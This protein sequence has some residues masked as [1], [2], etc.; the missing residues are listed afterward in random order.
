M[1]WE[2]I[3]DQHPLETLTTERLLTIR[4]LEVAIPSI[5]DL[6]PNLGSLAHIIDRCLRKHKAERTPS[7]RA[8]LDE[9]DAF[10][11]SPRAPI[12]DH[13]RQASPLRATRAPSRGDAGRAVRALTTAVITA[14]RG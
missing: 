4:D 11:A 1:L 7:A 14:A 3:A 10:S 5:A 13:A 6:F 12:D 2:L 9:L 8:L